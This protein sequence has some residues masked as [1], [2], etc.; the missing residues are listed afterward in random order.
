MRIYHHHFTRPHRPTLQPNQI[1]RQYLLLAGSYRE[2][3]VENA[4]TDDFGWKFLDNGLIEDSAPVGD[5]STNLTH[6]TSLAVSSRLQ[7]AIKYC[8]NVRKTGAAGQ[9]FE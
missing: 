2:N 1:L 9:T 4:A 5:V 7:N 3:T 6:M 8:T